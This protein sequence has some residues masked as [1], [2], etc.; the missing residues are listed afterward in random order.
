MEGVSL[1]THHSL[2]VMAATV[3]AMSVKIIRVVAVMATPI[4][5]F[6]GHQNGHQKCSRVLGMAGERVLDNAYSP[7]DFLKLTGSYKGKEFQLEKFQLE[8]N[9]HM[10]QLG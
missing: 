4:R 2:S 9:L 10:R 3:P 8:S 5:H 7:F 6:Y 1:A